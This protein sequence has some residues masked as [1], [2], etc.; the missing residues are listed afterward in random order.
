[1]DILTHTKFLFPEIESS[2]DKVWMGWQ[3]WHQD[4]DDIVDEYDFEN[5]Q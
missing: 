4:L 2:N 3:K 5:S 1:L